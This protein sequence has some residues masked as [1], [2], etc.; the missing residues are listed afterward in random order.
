MWQGRGHAAWDPSGS[1]CPGTHG[2]SCPCCR[3]FGASQ[4]PGLSWQHGGQGTKG[5]HGGRA[6]HGRDDPCS[7][8][9]AEFSRPAS[10]SENHDAGTEGEKRDEDGEFDSR[11]R[12]ETEDEEVTTPTKIKELKVQTRQAE[13]G[14]VEG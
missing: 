3:A 9:W 1:L 8:P 2:T 12:S 10:V 14:E 6:W 13:E 4:P 11:R 5:C 7:P